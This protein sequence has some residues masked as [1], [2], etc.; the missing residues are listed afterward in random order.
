MLK[1]ISKVSDF[2]QPMES[3][4]R[5]QAVVLHEP[6]AHTSPKVAPARL[7]DAIGTPA[8]STESYDR[9]HRSTID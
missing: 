7:G 4:R 9:G 3:K 6:V 5:D 8:T 2:L 1:W